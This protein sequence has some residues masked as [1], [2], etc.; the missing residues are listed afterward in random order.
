MSSEQSYKDALIAELENVTVLVHDIDVSKFIL[1]ALLPPEEQLKQAE[2]RIAEIDAF[3]AQIN[4][5]A[6]EIAYHSDNYV[7]GQRQFWTQM[8]EKL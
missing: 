3:V 8:S 2:A 1:T 5:L 4:A 6:K 7:G